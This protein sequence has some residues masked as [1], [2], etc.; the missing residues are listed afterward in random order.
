MAH[1]NIAYVVATSS[2]ET[3]VNDLF[4]H[5]QKKSGRVHRLGSAKNVVSFMSGDTDI[6]ATLTT[7]LY[8]GSNF[9]YYSL[10]SSTQSLN[11]Q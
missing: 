8:M 10:F 2:K 11:K 3:A 9:N 1:D 4:A 6:V 7:S 5:A